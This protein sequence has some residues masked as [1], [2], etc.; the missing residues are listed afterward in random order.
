MNWSCFAAVFRKTCN[1]KIV[2]LQTNECISWKL[3]FQTFVSRRGRKFPI[4]IDE[5]KSLVKVL[6]NF[7]EI[8]LHSCK[9]TD[10]TRVCGRLFSARARVAG[11]ERV[12]DRAAR[13]SN[14]VLF[15]SYILLCLSH[16]VRAS[17][18]GEETT[19]QQ[20]HDSVVQGPR[21]IITPRAVRLILSGIPLSL[22]Y[23]IYICKTPRL[24]IR[25]R[26]K[27]SKNL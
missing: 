4:R 23:Y 18:H 1:G 9:N 13:G 5:R 26:G 25:G 20:Q 8:E 7:V 15:S 17:W 22:T 19:Q 12:F 14:S 10:P 24:R 3:Y 2:D 27:S 21:S 11:P 16:L 6:S